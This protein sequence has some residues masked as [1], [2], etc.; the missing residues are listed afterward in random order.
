MFGVILMLAYLALV[1]YMVWLFT[2]FVSA[3]EKMADS[4]EDYV[5][6]SKQK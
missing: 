6:Q 3:H 1:A 5:R 2:R 4:M